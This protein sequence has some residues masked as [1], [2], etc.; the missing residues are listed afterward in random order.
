[1]WS[2]MNILHDKN[3][4]KSAKSWIW[5]CI[6]H[7]AIWEQGLVVRKRFGVLH[8]DVNEYHD[9]IQY[10][11]FSFWNYHFEIY[12][13]FMTIYTTNPNIGLQWRVVTSQ[14]DAWALVAL[15]SSKGECSATVFYHNT[16]FSYL[17]GPN[18]RTHRKIEDS[19][20]CRSIFSVSLNGNLSRHLPLPQ[21]CT[22]PP[23]LR[24]SSLPVLFSGLKWTHWSS[25]I[26]NSAITFCT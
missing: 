13:N 1:M 9:N 4:W 22:Q 26:Q 3:Y 6:T 21:P 24:S 14:G 8:F 19:G 17:F 11:D 12:Y 23:T 2:T 18:R 5:P 7:F 15:S 16:Q 20:F 25:L 10:E